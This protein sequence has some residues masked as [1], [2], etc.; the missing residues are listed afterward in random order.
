MPRFATRRP[1]TATRGTAP[2]RAA[3]EA[4]DCTAR[5]PFPFPLSPSPFP[6]LLPGSRAAAAAAP[7]PERSERRW[8]RAGP[9]PRRGHGALLAPGAERGGAAAAAALRAAPRRRRHQHRPGRSAGGAAA[10]TGVPGPRCA[11]GVSGWAGKLGGQR[12]LLLRQK[13]SILS[14]RA[15]L[16]SG[17]RAQLLR[18]RLGRLGPAGE[19]AVFLQCEHKLRSPGAA[20][21]NVRWPSGGAPLPLPPPSAAGREGAG[22]APLRAGLVTVLWLL[23]GS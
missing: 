7:G 10:A 23:E 9:G 3:E 4:S 6:L 20:S 21:R 17:V 18:P 14:R 1:V 16:S 15:G 8:C 22:A 11:L 13:T 5:L 12:F 19:A 2:G